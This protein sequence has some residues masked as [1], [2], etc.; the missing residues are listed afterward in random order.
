VVRRLVV[1]RI[2]RRLAALLTA[3]L[4]VLLALA[5]AAAASGTRSVVYRGYRVA[6]P[7]G[8]PVFRLSA[9][10]TV[11]VRFNRHA[12]YLG[13]PSSRQACPAS[14]LGRTEAILVS[15][16]LS[17]AARSGA[18]VLA[19][20]TTPGAQAEGGSQA[21]ISLA[22]RGVQITATWNHSPQTVN[23]ALGMRVAHASPA[24]AAAASLMAAPTA[25]TALAGPQGKAASGPKAGAATVYTGLGFDVCSTPSAAQMTAW[26]SSPYRGIGVYI[27]GVNMACSQPN[28]TAAWV[29]A[30]WAAGWHLVPI[31]VGLQAPGNDCGCSP[32]SSNTTTANGQGVAAATDAVT[33]AQAVG[34]EAASPIY[35]DMEGYTRSTTH[36]AAVLAFLSGWTAELHAQGYTSGVYSSADSG[37]VDLVGQV[38]T[39]YLEPDDLWIARW[40]GAQNTVDPNVPAGDWANHQRLHQYSGGLNQTYGG[41]KLNIDQDY[42][43]G[44]TAYGGPVPGP[45]LRV[46]PTANGAINLTASWP[47]GAGLTAWRVLGGPNPTTVAPIG[48]NRSKGAT[49][50]IAEHSAFPYYEVQA[51]GAGGVVLAQSPTVQTRSHLALYGK[52]AFVPAKGLVGIPSGCFTGSACRMALTVSAGRR[53]LARTGRE[54]LASSGGLLYFKLTSSAR[55]MVTHAPGRRLAVKVQAKDVSGTAATTSLSL[56]PFSTTG[57]GPRRSVGDASSIRIIGLRDFVFRGSVGGILAGCVGSSPCSIMTTITAGRNTIATTRAETI[58]ANEAAYLTFHLNP[59]GRTLLAKAHG[60]QLGARVTL[61]S[62]SAAAHASIALS[63]FS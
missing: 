45:A 51:L 48:Q 13:V 28:Q 9:N 26:G 47:G 8:W 44:A 14:A 32:V 54:Y 63:S 25:H 56:V 42:L 17:G 29:A 12:V 6:V 59:V 41:V 34:I 1:H 33:H 38:G 57:S 5:G 15:P 49:T 18:R 39:G 20:V 62:H 23:R 46:S 22:R 35:D 31:Y 3:V 40:N 52:S 43:D 50:T 27:G 55:S 16:L 11:C 7:V 21:Q 36:T 37:I 4:V 30:Q 58:G 61:T 10:S 53:V 2:V 24:S 19:P 60:N